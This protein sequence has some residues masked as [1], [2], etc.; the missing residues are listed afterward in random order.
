MRHCSWHIISAGL[1][2]GAI[3]WLGYTAFGF[4]TASIFS[5]GFAIGFGLWLC[6]PSTTDFRSIR[7]P[8]WISLSL[9]VAHRVEEKVS[10]FF[11]VLAEI[12]GVPTP[13]V[14]SWQVISL[15]LGSVGAWILVPILTRF[16]HPLGGYLAWTFFS[17]MGITE[18]AHFIL[19]FVRADSNGYFPGVVTAALLAPFAWW[20]MSV[21]IK[22]HRQ[23]AFPR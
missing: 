21:L 3:L 22:P 23:A 5:S 14:L 7:V 10:G 6:F 2:T 18:L 4:W 19:P 17:A 8:Y 15:V 11:P 9:F 1:F 16:R 13:S 20:G 12:T